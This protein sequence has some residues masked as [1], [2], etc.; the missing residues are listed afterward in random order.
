[1]SLETTNGKWYRRHYVVGNH[2]R[3]QYLRIEYTGICAS[4]IANETGGVNECRRRQE[5]I[6][7]ATTD[8]LGSHSRHRQHHEWIGTMGVGH[9]GFLSVMVY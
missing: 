1:M 3:D 9:V 6:G 7:M 8:S 2:T 4:V 5:G